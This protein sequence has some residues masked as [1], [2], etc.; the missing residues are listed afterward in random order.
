LTKGG[1]LGGSAP[2]ADA[3]PAPPRRAKGDADRDAGNGAAASPGLTSALVVGAVVVGVALLVLIVVV[4]VRR[5][6]VKR[7]VEEAALE[8]ALPQ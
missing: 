3:R 8:E 2:A 7:H 1:L 6:R 4:V 5:R